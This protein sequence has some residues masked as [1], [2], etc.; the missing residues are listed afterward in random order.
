M[1]RAYSKLHDHKTST[2]CLWIRGILASSDTSVSVTTFGL[3]EFSSIAGWRR[4]VLRAMDPSTTVLAEI[5]DL[6]AAESWAGI[7]GAMKDGLYEALGA[8]SLLRDLV[9]IPEGDWQSALESWHIQV[10]AAGEEGQATTRRPKAVELGRA[11]ALRRVARLALGLTAVA[12]LPTAPSGGTMEVPASTA[13]GATGGR[14][15]SRLATACSAPPRAGGLCSGAR[16]CASCC[17][18]LWHPGQGDVSCPIIVFPECI[19]ALGFVRCCSWPV[20]PLPF[21]G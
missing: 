6:G 15:V 7:S 20:R 12:T 10:P 8:P 13:A 11:H 21:P 14:G 2:S 4:L 9:H 18:C 5:R 17:S 3:L 1:G 16:R 19:L